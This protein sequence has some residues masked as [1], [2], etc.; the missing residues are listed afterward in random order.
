MGIFADES[1]V[2]RVQTD[3][4]KLRRKAAQTDDREVLTEKHIRRDLKLRQAEHLMHFLVTVMIGII[5]VFF[6][7]IIPNRVQMGVA[8]G[9]GLSV[10]LGYM[11]W[12]L[13]YV[14]RYARLGREIHV[15]Q[16]TVEHQKRRGRQ[17]YPVKR[18]TFLAPLVILSLRGF[19]TLRMPK[20]VYFSWSKENR[21]VMEDAVSI[22]RPGSKVY[23]VSFDH[24]HAVE[25]YPYSLFR[26]EGD[27][28]EFTL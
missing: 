26:W 24:V 5:V 4:Q 22:M 18:G 17:R 28:E 27:T 1:H 25:V 11:V 14:F 15:Y 9:I 23:V 8:L 19:K 3:D 20:N 2:E 13:V 6:V 16:T 10:I 12:D 21:C 7:M